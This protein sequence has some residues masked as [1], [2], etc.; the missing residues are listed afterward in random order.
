MNKILHRWKQA[1]YVPAEDIR[2]GDRKPVPKGASGD[3]GA[4]ELEAIQ[5]VLKEG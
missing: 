5:R 1:G 2:L 3:L 4:A